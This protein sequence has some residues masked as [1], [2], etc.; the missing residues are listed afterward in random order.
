MEA[1]MQERAKT[2]L[3]TPGRGFRY[4]FASMAKAKFNPLEIPNYTVE[5]SAR[6]LL[7]PIS[8]VRYWTIGESGAAPL[9]SIFSRRP[10]LLSFK[11]LVELYVL[12]SLRE[13][14]DIGLPR[15]RRSVEELRIEKPSKFP[16]ADYQLATSGR[17]IYLEGNGDELVNLTGG[18]Q[19]AFKA[20]L[21]P[22]LKR[23]ERNPKGIAERLFPF[24]SRQ[25]QQHPERA[26]KCV[27]IDPLVAFGMPVLVNSRISTAFLMSRR[28]G[29]ASISKLA[30]D[31]GRSETEIEEAISLEEAKSAA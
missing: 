18:G 26:P 28:K 23:V 25:H 21:N 19:H 12:E 22:F 5:E 31:Y 29:G 7:V 4:T 17:R 24:T 9:T 27:V 10:I 20:I 16:L 1:E 30:R 2:P 11:N 6:Y 8:T 3:T 14:H 13:I 15:I